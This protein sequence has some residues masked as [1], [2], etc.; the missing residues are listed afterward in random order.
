MLWFCI[1]T[2]GELIKIYPLLRLAT[3]RQ[4]PWFVL[5]TGQSP[6]NF[7][8]QWKDF[9]LPDERFGFLTRTSHDL[10]SSKAALKWFLSANLQTPSSLKRTIAEVA[11]TVPSKDDHWL[12]HGDTLSTLLGSRYAR[13]LKVPLSHVEAGLRSEDLFNPFPEEINRRLVS[14]LAQTHFA[15]DDRAFQNLKTAKVKGNLVCTEGNTQLDTIRLVLND[16]VAGD[17]PPLPYVIANIHRFENLN[18]S[19]RWATM[20]DVLTKTAH[21]KAPVYLVLH[22]PT[23]DK[24]KGDPKT[25][26]RLT[27]AGVRLLPRQPFTQFIHLLSHAD[28]A[29]SDGGSNQEECFYLGKPCLLLRES[30]ERIEGLD[31]PCLLTR[32]KTELID[33]FLKDPSKFASPAIL[34][35]RSPSKIILDCLSAQSAGVI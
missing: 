30:T 23:Q 24:L 9:K 12:V 26:R 18:S 10:H 29:I 32:F 28:F 27:E 17:I 21:E 19:S 22:P 35:Q 31:G 4:Q 2:A 20:I 1:G 3:D 6:V 34:H 25:S 15:Q 7:K 33:R 16:F 8:N 14:R 5:A 11:G 13:M